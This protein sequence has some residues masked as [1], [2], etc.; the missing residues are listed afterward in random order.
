LRVKDHWEREAQNWLRWARTP[1]FDA[2]WRYREAFLEEVLPA[3]GRATLEIGCGE[4]RVARDLKARGHRVTAIDA[5]PTLVSAAAELDGDSQYL[6]APAEK[7]PFADGRFD[8]VVAYNSLMD[9]DDMT[10]AVAEAAR[11]LERGGRLAACI[12]HPFTD[13]G[14]FADATGDPP[15]VVNGTYRGT[16]RFEQTFERDGLTMDFAGWQHDLET[17]SRAFEAAGLLIERLR[18]PAP[19]SAR[20]LIWKRW[21]RIPMFLMLRAVKVER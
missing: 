9:V 7:L 19:G 11:V 1:H 13:A 5:S 3:P 8:L 6:I 17:Y 20:E 12:T 10:T 18:E 21:N 15:F 2:Y 4:G 16:R 14:Q